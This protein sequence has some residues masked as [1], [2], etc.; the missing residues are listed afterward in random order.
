MFNAIW[1]FFS[2]HKEKHT[3]YKYKSKHKLVLYVNQRK[4]DKDAVYDEIAEKL[5][6]DWYII[7][8]YYCP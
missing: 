5:G 8:E 4:W 3:F 7:K 2:W 6:K 1:D